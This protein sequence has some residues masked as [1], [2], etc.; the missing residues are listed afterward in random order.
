MFKFCGI[1]MLGSHGLLITE[2]QINARVSLGC[3]NLIDR[4]GKYLNMFIRL[5]LQLDF[6]SAKR[7]NGR[8]HFSH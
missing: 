2:P 1:L 5:A 4:D 3:V 6:T 7:R 8:K